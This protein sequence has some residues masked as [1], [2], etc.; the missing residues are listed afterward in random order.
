VPE[1]A[2]ILLY[3]LLAAASPITV[4][5]TLVVLGSGRGRENGIVFAGAFVL[6]QSIAFLV[7]LFVGSAFTENAHE[8][9]TAAIEL[10]TGAVLLVIAVRGRP[11][12]MP[13]QAGSAPRSEALFARLT[14]VTPRISFGIGFLLGI[15]VKRLFITILAAATVALAGLAPVEEAGLGVL[16]V[17]VASLTVSIPVGLYVVFGTRSDE[18]MAASRGWI[19]GH[20]QM[21]TF[22]S[23]LAVGIL[24]VL[25]ALIRLLS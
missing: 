1:V 18:L 16:Y 25:D 19:A 15:G 20:E 5:A 11:P 9:A 10:A 24:F 13:R 4:L 12:H 23:A 21:L 2:R 3:G 8:T 22:V 6:G 14:R 17:V 7:A